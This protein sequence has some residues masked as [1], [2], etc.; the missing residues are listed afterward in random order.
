MDFVI[1]G[2]KGKEGFYNFTG[3]FQ[4][5]LSRISLKGLHI[6]DLLLVSQAMKMLGTSKNVVSTPPSIL[7][8]TFSTKS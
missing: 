2:V 6:V 5:L 8:P 7:T 1:S 4:M 3:L